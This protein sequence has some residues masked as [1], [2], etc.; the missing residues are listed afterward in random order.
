VAA[1]LPDEGKHVAT[2][3]VSHRSPDIDRAER[4]ALSIRAAGHEVWLDRW[5]L[6]VGDSVVGGIDRGLADANYLVLCY[7]SLDV[8]AP[9][10]ARE[11][12][13]TLARQLEG[14]DVRLLPVRLSGGE[15]PAVLAD[16][17]YADL[18]S[19]WDG[20]VRELLAALR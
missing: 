5:Q 6:R 3:F 12:M 16:I 15:P 7:S 13:S 10:T 19:D 17:R 11:W 14:A 4:L 20:G 9:W 8:T 2:V 18:V 1:T